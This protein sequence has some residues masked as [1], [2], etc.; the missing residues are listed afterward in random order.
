[1][2]LRGESDMENNIDIRVL[3]KADMQNYKKIRL[4]LLSKEPKSF[5]SSYE[6][7]SQFDDRMWINRL[8]KEHVITLGAFDNNEIVGVSVSV[9]NPRSKIQ[10]VATLNS[11][12]VKKNYRQ[13]N[14]GVAMIKKILGQLKDR[15]VEVLN[16]SVVTTN[17]SAINLYK[18]LGFTIYGE[19]EKAIKYQGKYINLYLMKKEVL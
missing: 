15:K 13:K 5:G 6:E 2:G 11:M 9:G 1:M 8:S 18:K 16:L 3:T 12:F 14:I 19:E 7:E 4:E 10:H 17:T